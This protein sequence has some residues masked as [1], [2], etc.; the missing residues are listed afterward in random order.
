MTL[1]FFIDQCVPNSVNLTLAEM[2][3]EVLLLREY[4]P[5]NSPDTIVIATAQEF[6]SILISLNGDFADI[7][8]YP[9]SNYLGII[10]LQLK[11]HPEILPKIIKQLINYLSNY[12]SPK[13][14]QGKLFIVEV[15]KIRIRT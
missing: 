10:S 1:K 2:G 13:H 12:P 4:I 7:I 6:Q 3:Y 15:S 9:P 5:I 11:N 14:Y 8:N